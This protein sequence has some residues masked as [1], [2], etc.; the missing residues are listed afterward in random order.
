MAAHALYGQN[1]HPGS[2]GG[3]CEIAFE[4]EDYVKEIRRADTQPEH[5]AP[6]N[7]GPERGR[8]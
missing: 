5:S 7:A 2:W 3:I 4:L 8:F 6:K 1:G